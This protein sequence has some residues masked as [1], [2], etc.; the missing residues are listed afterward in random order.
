ML[1]DTICYIPKDEKI[2]RV[3]IML[4][5]YGADGNDLISM[6][7]FMAEH[8]SNTV[9]YAPNAPEQMDFMSGFKW[10]DI[11]IDA[12]V[13]VFSHSDYIEKLMTRGKNVL[14]LINDFIDHICQK[15]QLKREQVFL[16]GFSQG[17]LLALMSG[18]LFEPQLS[19]V[20]A[21]S[22]VPLMLNDVLLPQNVKSKPPVLLTHGTDDDVVPFIAMQ[23][24]QNTL[25]NIDTVV[26]THV[27]PGMGHNI[28]Q[29]CVMA[30][31]NFIKNI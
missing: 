3:V 11:E 4:H 8:L 17:G 16:M 7:P 29:S 20:I 28:D 10:F 19:G 12:S 27:V 6:A 1:S 30:M 9:F 25:K 14:P 26:Q 2:E 24:T 5:G 23:M 15:H 22:A 21:C 31:I 13:A 18:V